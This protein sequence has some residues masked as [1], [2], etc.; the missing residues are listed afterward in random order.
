MLLII[1]C[2]LDNSLCAKQFMHTV[3]IHIPDFPGLKMP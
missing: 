2:T 3:F 1:T